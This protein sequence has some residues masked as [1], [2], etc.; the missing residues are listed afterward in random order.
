[1]ATVRYWSDVPQSLRYISYD[2]TLK[3]FIGAD[4]Q[5][6]SMLSITSRYTSIE[7]KYHTTRKTIK[8]A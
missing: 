4:S 1:M 8:Y 5:N 2:D 7:Q 3:S 6:S